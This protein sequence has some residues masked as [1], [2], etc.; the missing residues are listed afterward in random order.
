MDGTAANHVDISNEVERIDEVHKRKQAQR[1]AAVS[2][3]ENLEQQM[4]QL[5][6]IFDSD[7]DTRHPAQDSLSCHVHSFLE[8]C[9]AVVNNTNVGVLSDDSLLS[10]VQSSTF[11]NSGHKPISDPILTV[12]SPP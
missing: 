11:A 2:S 4:A 6:V 5:P 1:Q 3:F 9:A 8:I 10:K 12:P 7:L